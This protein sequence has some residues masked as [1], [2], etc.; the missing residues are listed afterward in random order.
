MTQISDVSL[1]RFL[2]KFELMDFLWFLLIVLFYLY[3]IFT[4]VSRGSQKSF[5]ST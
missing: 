2:D 5:H 1:K 4:I 3:V